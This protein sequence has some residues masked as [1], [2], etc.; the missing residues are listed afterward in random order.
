VTGSSG[1]SIDRVAVRRNV[2]RLLLFVGALVVVAGFAAALVGVLVAGDEHGGRADKHP[3]LGVVLVIGLPLLVL[4]LCFLILRPIMR[5]S[6]FQAVMQFGWSERRAVYKTVKAGRP[7][8]DRDVRVVRASLTYLERT[9][10]SLWIWPTLAVLFVLN[11]LL[12]HGPFRWLMLALAVVYAA[13]VPFAIRQRR[14]VILR[15]RDALSRGES[16]SPVSGPIG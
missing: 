3:V 7:L 16:S 6:S 5:G 14:R 15:Y 11:G 2:R 4:A 10:W 12:Q 13:L 9:A 8:T 1:D